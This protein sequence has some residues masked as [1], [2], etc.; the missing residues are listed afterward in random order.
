MYRNLPVGMSHL[1]DCAFS[2]YDV[3]FSVWVTFWYPACLGHMNWFSLSWIIQ[4]CLNNIY[5]WI[6]DYL[7]VIH[8]DWGWKFLCQGHDIGRSDSWTVE[9]IFCKG[10]KE[11][12]KYN[13]YKWSII[14]DKIHQVF[15]NFRKTSDEVWINSSTIISFI[16]IRFGYIYICICLIRFI[17]NG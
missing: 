5:F 16:S 6:L 1:A 3:V 13:F 4:I 11:Y 9:T 2:H 17:F 10:K 8:M 7:H 15:R 12:K 14:F